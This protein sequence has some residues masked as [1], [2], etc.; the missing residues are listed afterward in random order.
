[1]V[2]HLPEV[3]LLVDLT[4]SLP[5]VTRGLGRRMV[6]APVSGGVSGATAGSLTAMVGGDLEAV[7]R[8]ALAGLG[9]PVV[10]DQPVTRGAEARGDR[11]SHPP[12]ADQGEPH[13][14]GSE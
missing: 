14:G 11:R 3:P 6:D 8:Q 10:Q 4:S 2:R 12:R 13:S 5:S 9:R 1:V 7:P